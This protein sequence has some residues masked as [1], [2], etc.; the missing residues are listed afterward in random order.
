MH[1]TA[2][3]QIHQPQPEEDISPFSGPALTP[4]RSHT[5]TQLRVARSHA[6][7]KHETEPKPI[8]RMRVSCVD[9]FTSI[10]EMCTRML[11]ACF[12]AAIWCTSPV[13][14]A[15]KPQMARNGRASMAWNR[16]MLELG[17][18]AP[19]PQN[20]ACAC[21]CHIEFSKWPPA[22]AKHPVRAGNLLLEPTASTCLRLR[23][24]LFGS[25]VWISALFG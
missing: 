23:M 11:A 20:V 3:T 9:Y 13:K 22:L 16:R 12:A 21:S 18:R 1:T 17:A 15:L 4:L 10:S 6:R 24:K 8:S 14:P 19:E 5:P 2:K 7:H 25:Y